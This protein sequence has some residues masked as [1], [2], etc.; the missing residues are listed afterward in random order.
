MKIK[1][2]ENLTRFAKLV[3]KKAPMYVVGGYVRNALL[4]IGNTDIDLSSKLTPD[5]LEKLTQDS[6]YKIVV[7]DKKL[8]SVNI[9]CGDEV[10]EH[11]T[12]RREKYA[13]GGQHSP[14]EVQFINDINE[15]AKR[16]DFT[17]N[18]MYYNIL[19]DEI[20]D[21]YSGK[22]D[23]DKKVIRCIETPEFVFENDGLRILR[24]VRLAS[25]L[26]FRISR[27][28]FLMAK[29]MAYRVNDITGTRKEKELSLILMSSEKY[30]I[31]N[32][33]SHIRGLHLINKLNL[34][35]AIFLGANKIRYDMVKRVA[36]NERFLGL[37]IDLINSLNPDCVAYYL[38][39]SLGN[40]GLMLSKTKTDEIIEMV[41]A[42]F[43]ALNGI[44]N[45]KYFFTYFDTFPLVSGF[46]Q[47]KAK[48]KF[49]KYNFFYN[50]IIKYKIPIQIKD[51]KITGKDL[52]ENFPS[53]SSKKYQT[54]LTDLLDKVFE[55]K[56]VN[57]KEQLLKEVEK[58]VN[59]L[60]NN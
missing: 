12:F 28:T 40:S 51:L 32:K 55:A 26:N 35:H 25:E 44:S 13:K 49:M 38:E 58:D 17:V 52:K 46:L 29:Q 39:E 56:L 54:I 33:K 53:I 9:I 21:I 11:T 10:W 14:E 8:G 37:I 2:S 57:E 27:D 22:L 60:T 19:K 36:A 34:W 20:V 50:Y 41:S 42:Y 16:R 4:G 24:M 23:L 43:D 31:S 3:S 6:P 15:D 47:K 1:V 30:K 18:A 48:F 7:K 5:D 45:K 59:T